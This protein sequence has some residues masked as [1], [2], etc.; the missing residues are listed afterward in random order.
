MKEIIIFT[1]IQ[2]ILFVGVY[3]MLTLLFDTI[4]NVYVNYKIRKE[5]ERVE[6]EK[7]TKITPE[8]DLII[9]GKKY[10]LVLKEEEEK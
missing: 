2:T 9:N 3:T 8:G 1:T 6:K 7:Q 10:K 4:A 5:E